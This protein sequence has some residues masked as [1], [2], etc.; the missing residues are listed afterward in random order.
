MNNKLF[1]QLLRPCDNT[2]CKNDDPNPK[3]FLI[4][5]IKDFNHD[6]CNWCA[7]CIER[8]KDMVDITER[9]YKETGKTF[10]NN[11]NKLFGIKS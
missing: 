3:L 8:D 9:R 6:V 4:Q 7:E 11:K 1:N 5:L 2:D 10:I